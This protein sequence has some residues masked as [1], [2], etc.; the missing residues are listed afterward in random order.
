MGGS[1]GGGTLD[2]HDVGLQTLGEILQGESIQNLNAELSREAVMWDGT[3][4]MYRA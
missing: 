4:E 1:F 2:S 3:L